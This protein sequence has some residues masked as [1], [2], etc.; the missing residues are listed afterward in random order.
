[1]TQQARTCPAGDDFRIELG[2][3]PCGG[4]NERDHPA[5]FP[6]SWERPMAL[7]SGVLFDE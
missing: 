2:A 3:G 4:N 6:K 5:Y 1:M 7:S